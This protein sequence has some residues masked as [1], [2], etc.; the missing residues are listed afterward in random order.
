MLSQAGSSA[1]TISIIAFNATGKWQLLSGSIQPTFSGWSPMDFP[2]I[3][4][5][6]L[7]VISSLLP[8]R[9]VSVWI[10]SSLGRSWTPTSWH[11]RTGWVCTCSRLFSEDEWCM[12]VPGHF[13]CTS[14]VL[15]GLMLAW[16]S[17][18]VGFIA[19]P[20]VLESQGLNYPT[21]S[22]LDSA[23][24]AFKHEPRHRAC[25]R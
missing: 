20:I 25:S 10:S 15:L 6:F 13:T 3:T 21:N 14:E 24:N 5:H 4:W 12:L 23:I 7:D 11:M 1:A 22:D 19:S 2:W 18:I 16:R 17:D 8:S 9:V